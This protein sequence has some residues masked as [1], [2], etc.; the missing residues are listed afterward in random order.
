MIGDSLL[1]SALIGLMLAWAIVMGLGMKANAHEPLLAALAIIGCWGVFVTVG[2]YYLPT[3]IDQ[4][5][6]VSSGI[7]MLVFGIMYFY[8]ASGRPLLPAVR[9]TAFFIFTL[10]E[11][12]ISVIL[13][14]MS[15]V[16]A[17]VLL[18]VLNPKSVANP[19]TYHVLVGILIGVFAMILFIAAVFF[20]DA[21]TTITGK[22]RTVVGIT[23]L[24]RGRT[25]INLV[26]CPFCKSRYPALEGDIIAAKASPNHT[27]FCR[28][29][30]H[31]AT[32]TV[33]YV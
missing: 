2:H 23:K 25:P 8:R 19:T 24:H 14:V 27:V 21:L 4:Y 12:G 16:L 10:A 18:P 13:A 32:I 28:Y 3:P 11:L 29:C 5:F 15:A 17:E 33:E 26:S 1:S 6:A 20:N 31:A 30:Q 22:G 7:A 9:T